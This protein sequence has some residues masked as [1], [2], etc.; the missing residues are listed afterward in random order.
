MGPQA[1]SDHPHDP[2]ALRRGQAG[3]A[4]ADRRDGRAVWSARSPRGAAAW[5]Q[6]AERRA[7]W[8][9]CEGEAEG[10]RRT[11]RSAAIGCEKVATQIRQRVKGEPI[12]DRI[13]SL[14]DPDA[15]PIR[16]GKLW[17]ADEFGFVVAVGRG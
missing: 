13:V 14:H 10:G 9:G 1:Q 7:S 4:E 11:W 6:V 5:L 15:R 3:G 8:A 16:K 12:K 2:P 17:E